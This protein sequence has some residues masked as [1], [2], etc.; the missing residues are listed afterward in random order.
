MRL[1]ES[2]AA[3]G[4]VGPMVASSPSPQLPSPHPLSLP[5]RAVDPSVA[6]DGIAV[7][8]V[9]PDA[10]PT[11]ELKVGGQSTFGQDAEEPTRATPL[12]TE[13]APGFLQVELHAVGGFRA[14]NAGILDLVSASSS[15]PATSSAHLVPPVAITRLLL[16]PELR[17]SEASDMS[18]YSPTVVQTPCGDP[19]ELSPTSLHLSSRSLVSARTRIVRLPR[20][21]FRT[22]STGMRVVESALASHPAAS[23]TSPAALS[24]PDAYDKTLSPLSE[25][26]AEADDSQSQG[27]FWRH[28]NPKEGSRV[29][30]GSLPATA[31]SARA[32]QPSP[33]TCV[34]DDITAGAPAV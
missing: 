28:A 8:C 31:E 10:V 2:E 12:V 30:I 4:G 7:V 27:W 29:V 5:P 25:V 22:Q 14:D 20:G 11:P 21:A 33:E 15:R 18:P 9:S 13:S 34:A 16:K 24:K 1:L 23:A 19:S 17:E 3:V 6:P 26:R 32:M